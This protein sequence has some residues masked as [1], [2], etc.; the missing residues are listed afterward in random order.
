[1]SVAKYPKEILRSLRSL[2]MTMNKPQILR[3][4]P[5]SQNPPLIHPPIMPRHAR[6][7]AQKIQ[8]HFLKIGAIHIFCMCIILHLCEIR[9]IFAAR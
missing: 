1:M 2:R 8:V 7:F 4:N 3:F 6:L 9:S 5:K